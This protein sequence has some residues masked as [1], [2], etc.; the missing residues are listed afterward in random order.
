MKTKEELEKLK[1]DWRRNPCWDIEE[2]EGFEEY[3]DQL[4]SFRLEYEKECDIA[5]EAKRQNM[6]K[7]ANVTISDRDNQYDGLS[8]RELFTAMAMQALI[9]SKADVG[10]NYIGE[11]AVMYADNLLEHLD[12]EP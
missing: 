5:W 3:H 12:N 10:A 8:K 1:E 2:T 4:H 7:H 6:F 11:L 9:Q